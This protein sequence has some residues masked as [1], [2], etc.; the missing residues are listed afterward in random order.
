[1]SHEH[2]VKLLAVAAGGVLSVPTCVL[3][4][5]DVGFALGFVWG[6]ITTIAID[7][8]R[9]RRGATK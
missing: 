2:V 7:V 3:L 1:M 5:L 4:G 9:L 8:I 6:V